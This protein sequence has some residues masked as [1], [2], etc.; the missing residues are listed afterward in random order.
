MAAFTNWLF[1]PGGLTPHGFCLLWEPWLIW[2]YGLA[3]TVTA[4]SYFAIPVVLMQ[5]ARRRRDLLFR[6]V[7][8]MFAAFILLCGTGHGLDLLTLWVPAYEF[9]AVVKAA[10]AL[11]SLGTALVLLRLLPRMLALP[12]PAQMRAANQALQA[13]EARY[14]DAFIHSPL[15]LHVLDADGTIVSVSDSWLDLLGYR[16]EEVT[17]RRIEE[18]HAPGEA[19]HFAERW[20]QMLAAGRMRDQEARYRRRDG[21]PLDMLVTARLE[22]SPEGGVRVLGALVDVTARRAA[23]RALRETRSFLDTVVENLPVALFVKDAADLRYRLVNRGTEELLGLPREA[24]LGRDDHAALPPAMAEAMLAADRAALAAGG[25]QVTEAPVQPRRG[26]PRILRTRRLALPDAEGGPGY[27]L[28]FSEDV[29]VQHEAAAR[30]AHLA[31][32]DPLTGL[33]N[34]TLFRERL[35]ALAAAGPAALL[36]LDLDGFK[37]VNDELGHAAGDQVLVDVAGRVTTLPAPVEGVTPF[38]SRL[39]G[40]EFALILPGVADAAQAAAAA[41]GLL[42][43]LDAPFE[44]GARA[45]RLGASIGIALAPEHGPE[46]DALV[47]NAD[48]ALYEAKQAGGRIHR[49]FAPALRTAYDARRALEEEVTGAAGRGEFVLHYQPQVDLASGQVTGAE[50]LLRWRHRSRGLLA[51]GAFLPALEAGPAATIAAV[52]DWVLA[53]ACAQAGAWRQAGLPPLRIG[54]NLFGAQLSVGDLAGSVEAAL[55]RAG[56]PPE[57][58]ELELTETIALGSDAAL[59][60]PLHRLHRSGVGIAFDDF[61]TG[62]A[63]LATLKH[64]PLTRLKI[65]RGFVQDLGEDAH[66][67]AIVTAVLVLA[68]KLGLG[69]IAEGVETDRQAGILASLACREG[70]GYRYGRPM[71]AEQFAETLRLAPA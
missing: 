5:V 28:G 11:V 33:A 41:D 42:A 35:G 20:S 71:P 57:A 65:D 55:A 47:G 70:Q 51:P 8:W 32:Y 66:D 54:V 63:S 22:H 3:D 49:C 13:S 52:G 67:E 37:H 21:T 2:T 10:T 18:F 6:P 31:H 23:E 46:A 62:F 27:L 39:G 29:T 14:R 68:E 40:D 64:C 50:A 34:R 38:A 58:L 4:L 9:Q 61:G 16:R 25:T 12:S 44:I 56:L 48:L 7:F 15:P 45:F 1:N 30:V 60:A 59:L 17:G 53:E 36:L 69:V 24:L 26:E 43:R 19:A